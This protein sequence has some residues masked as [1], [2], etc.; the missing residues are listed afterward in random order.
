M[1]NVL[2]ENRDIIFPAFAA[3]ILG[4]VVFRILTSC[5]GLVQ[6]CQCFGGTG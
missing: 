3:G 2:S 6:R 4:I 5:S 1:Q